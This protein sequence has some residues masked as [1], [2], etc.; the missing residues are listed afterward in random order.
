MICKEDPSQI[1]KSQPS[2]LTTQKTTGD[3]FEPKF[4]AFLQFGSGH[5]TPGHAGAKVTRSFLSGL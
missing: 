4:D 1:L 3:T 5:V 2:T